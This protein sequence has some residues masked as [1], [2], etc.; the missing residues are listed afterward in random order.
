MAFL[1][2]SRAERAGEARRARGRWTGVL[3]QSRG[4]CHIHPVVVPVSG[5]IAASCAHDSTTRYL[6][7]SRLIRLHALAVEPRS[8]GWHWALRWTRRSGKSADTACRVVGGQH[9]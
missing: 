8:A 7:L 5:R 9:K 1:H 2:R 4:A 6:H 3:D